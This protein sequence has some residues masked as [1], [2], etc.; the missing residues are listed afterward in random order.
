[1]WHQQTFNYDS[2]KNNKTDTI[3]TAILLV[4]IQNLV[5]RGTHSRWNRQATDLPE[6]EVNNQRPPITP[7]II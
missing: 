1:M 5:P 3:I 7:T 2:I 6:K 4:Y